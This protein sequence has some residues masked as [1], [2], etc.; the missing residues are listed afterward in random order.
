MQ[1]WAQAMAVTHSP[2]TPRQLEVL[3]L[4]ARGLR[5]KEIATTLGISPGT[6]KNHLSAVFEAL[7]VTNRTEAA[8]ALSEM[9]ESDVAPDDQVPGFGAR[10]TIAILPFDNMSSDPEQ[11]FFAD[12]LVEDLTTRLSAWRWFPVIARTTTFALRGK[13]MA[14]PEIGRQLGARY[15]VEGSTRRVG[16]RVR[17]NVQLIDSSAASHVFAER[18]DR[19]MGD[20]F[21][22]QDEIVETLV[23]T[24]EPTLVRIEAMRT[25]HKKAET[26]DTWE[27]FQRGMA[28]AHLQTAEDWETAIRFYDEAITREPTFAPAHAARASA[29]FATGL[30]Q[31]AVLQT[32][33]VTAEEQERVTLAAIAGW[34]EAVESGRRA[35]E[36]DPLDAAGYVGMG[37]G[38]AMLGELPKAI[39]AIERGLE[40][41]PSNAVSCFGLANILQHTKIEQTPALYERAIR[42]SPNDP[43]LHHFEGAL[44]SVR[45]ALGEYDEAMRWARRSVDRQPEGT[46]GYR[47]IIAGCLALT[48]QLTEA[49]AE[50]A[51]LRAQAPDW[52]LKLARTLGVEAVVDK[53]KGAF[54]L[55]GWDV[56]E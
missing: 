53:L 28:H 3:E 38:L 47:P 48:G 33:P 25:R 23:G 17:I 24:L 10:P 15:V 18:Y 34:G 27:T 40:L 49:R 22:L 52:N 29:K 50:V 14:A 21:G 39:A 11:T 4:M 32:A 13:A 54:H 43:Y 9:Q 31:I 45:F 35:T 36:L 26:L 6:A 42:L 37:A 8:M 19:D 20:M 30:Q 16:N 44:A 12:G 1:D 51:D 56:P 2:L 41:D 5:N 55:A 46:Y 7:D